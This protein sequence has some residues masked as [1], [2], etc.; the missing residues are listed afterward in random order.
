MLSR[1]KRF[2]RI[3]AVLGLIPGLGTM[4]IQLGVAECQLAWGQTN[5]VVYRIE[6]IPGN[7]V[8]GY[9]VVIGTE[10]VM[11]GLDTW[12]PRH[13]YWFWQETAPMPADGWAL[14]HVSGEVVMLDILDLH[15]QDVDLVYLS[16][17]FSQYGPFQSLPNGS[18]FRM[19]FHPPGGGG[20]IPLGVFRASA[21]GD[22]DW[23]GYPP[24]GP[25]IMVAPESR[26]V[27]APIAHPGAIVN[28]DHILSE[29]LVPTTSVSMPGTR[30]A[31][32][33]SVKTECA[34][35]TP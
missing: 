8:L 23:Y 27:W 24:A 30:A 14:E 13:E 11:H 2:I 22:Q 15:P 4:I 3:V 16:E 34:A 10:P 35:R 25:R 1:T 21:N 20:P 5:L 9:V 19:M 6:N 17:A 26:L 7:L 18:W 12:A 31:T 29:P 33:G 32:W 28:A